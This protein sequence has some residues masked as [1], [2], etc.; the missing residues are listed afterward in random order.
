MNIFLPF[1]IPKLVKSLPFCI[2]EAWKRHP[3]R[4]EPPRIG[5]CWEY[6]DHNILFSF[7]QP[8]EEF[9]DPITNMLMSDPVILTT[10]N[11]V[12]DKSTI[13][14]H[15]LRYVLDLENNLKFMCSGEGTNYYFYLFSCQILNLTQ[16]IVS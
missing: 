5:H 11:N 8:P 4:A 15:L 7:Q 16:Y 13:C 14:R 2:P 3:F 10:S 9:V 1:H 12:V 6:S